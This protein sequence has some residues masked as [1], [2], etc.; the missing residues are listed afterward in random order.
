MPIPSPSDITKTL[1]AIRLWKPGAAVVLNLAEFRECKAKNKEGDIAESFFNKYVNDYKD[2][3]EKARAHYQGRPVMCVKSSSQILEYA[4]SELRI[5]ENGK[6]ECYEC[7]SFSYSAIGQLLLNDDVRLHYQILQ[8]GT[9]RAMGRGN[10]YYYRHN[11]VVLVPNGTDIP[12]DGSLPSNAL[13]IDAW[14]R[15]LGHSAESSLGVSAEHFAFQSSLEPVVVNYNSANE[16]NL[17]ETVRDFR[18][19]NP[20]FE[21]RRASAFA[22]IEIFGEEKPKASLL[23]SLSVINQ[24]A[25]HDKKKDDHSEVQVSPQPCQS[26]ACF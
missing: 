23:T 18:Q 13:I 10:K 15:S 11:S 14:L 19:D 8:V 1:D 16:K 17:E 4:K 5:I 25:Q 21:Q 7:S 3:S 24:T 6:T 22:K 2:D 12:K 9:M 26:R 20:D